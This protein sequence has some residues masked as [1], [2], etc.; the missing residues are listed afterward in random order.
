MV[1]IPA[2]DIEEGEGG[3]DESQPHELLTCDAVDDTSGQRKIHPF[4]RISAKPGP[5]P[6]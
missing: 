6:E 3:C 4:F 2:I 1:K 5:F